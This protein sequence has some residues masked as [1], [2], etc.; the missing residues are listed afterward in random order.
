MVT[1]LSGFI[2]A[3]SSE[4]AV[5]EPEVRPV[6]VITVEEREG[7]ETVSLAGTIES[8][9]QVDLAFRIGGRMTERLVDVG[10]MVEADQVI[11]RLDPADEENGLRA[12]EASLA[13]AEGQLSEARVNYDRQRHLY[14]RDIV[15]R[16]ALDRAEQTLTTAQAAADTAAAQVGIARRRLDDTELRA[17]AGGVV[18]AVGAEPGEVVQ[19]GRMI[20]QIARDEGKDAVFDVPAT[21]IGS[22]PPDPEIHV[23]LSLTPTV[24]AEGRV[25]EVAPRADSATGTFRVRVGLI[26]PPAE[27]RL[28]STV[29]GRTT[30]GGPAGLEVPASALTRS[31]GEPAVW[32]VDPTTRTVNLRPIGVSRFAQ[33][34]VVVSDGLEVGDI[35]VTAGVQALRPGQEVRLLGEAS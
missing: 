25:R 7:G 15:A 8:R 11:A 12:A 3:C 35:V 34:S 21:L 1:G 20:V 9:L 27:M 29:V 2:A 16:V 18:T 14:E 5:I 4:E 13:A 28:G 19:T 33:S 32:I 10:D 30:F 23:A 6:R 31:G 24:T 17:D 22:S 26:D